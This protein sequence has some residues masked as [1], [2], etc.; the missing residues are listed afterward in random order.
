LTCTGGGA[1]EKIAAVLIAAHVVADLI[2]Q[3]DDLVQRKKKLSFLVLHAAIHAVCSY[4]FLQSWTCWQAPLF[5][6]IVHALIDFVKQGFKQETATAFIADQLTHLVS[7]LGLAWWLV[8]SSWVPAF[9]GVGYKPI[10]V[11][12]GFIATV[13]GSSFLID[14]VAKRLMDENNL[15]LDGLVNGGKLIGQLER[16]LI[17]LFI[18]IGQPA[19]IGFLV[20]AKSI[21]R[22]EEAKK[23]RLA[24]YVLIGTLLSFSLAIALAS[25]T[26]WALK[27]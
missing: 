3:T 4:L 11:L 15:E 16:S 24:E 17:F 23:Q 21:L 9:S 6:L 25:A 19:G 20:A 26:M 8:G 18:F 2:L 14:K 12:A 1:T 10:I 5:V 7:L 13:Q 27:L 22:F